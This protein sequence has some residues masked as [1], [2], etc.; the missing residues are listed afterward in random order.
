VKRSPLKRGEGPTRRTPLKPTEGIP[1]AKS[2]KR[3]EPRPRIQRDT[4][5]AADV[6]RLVIARANG[7]C[8]RCGKTVTGQY[9]IHHRKPRGMGGTKDPA[10]NSPANLLLLCGSATSPD[11]CHTAVERFRASAVT[12]GFVVAQS[13]DPEAVPVKM[14]NGW[15]LLRSDGTRVPTV[16]PEIQL[17]D[18]NDE[19]GED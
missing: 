12:T 18:E 19:D 8:E 14:R 11:G 15:W 17:E 7:C 3:G 9:S 6:R 16:R 1:T 4:G 5:P 13:A 2:L 10:I